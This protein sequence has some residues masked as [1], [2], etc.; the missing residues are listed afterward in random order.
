[1]KRR[2]PYLALLAAALVG[3]WV[4]DHLIVPWVQQVAGYDRIR[5]R[6]LSVVLGHWVF[7]Q[8]PRVLVCIAVWLVG[9]RFGLMPSLRKSFASGGSWRRVATTGLL[10]TAVFLVLTVAIGAAAGG[11]FGFHPYFPKMA[12]DVVSNMYEEIVYRGL[13]FSAFYGVVTATRFPLAGA[14]DRAGLSSAP[15]ARAPSSRWGM[16]STPLP[17]ASW[18][19]SSPWYSSIPGLRRVHSGLHGSRIRSVISSGT[20]SSGCEAA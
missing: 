6:D 3:W 19:G 5:D 18:S 4:S 17:C 2:L 10:A 20:P 15:S 14:L 9:S 16:S 11:T 7:G 1:M 13:M 8:L 12:G